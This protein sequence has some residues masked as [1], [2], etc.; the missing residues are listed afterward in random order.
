MHLTPEYFAPELWQRL[1]SNYNK[2]KEE[3]FS[4]QASFDVYAMGLTVYFMCTRRHLL[5]FLE[6]RKDNDR[7]TS[8]VFM[9]ELVS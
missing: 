2:L 4:P 6:R 7:Q 3:Q 9:A 5:K 1:V 8:F